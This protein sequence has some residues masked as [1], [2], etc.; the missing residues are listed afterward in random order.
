MFRHILSTFS[1]SLY[2]VPVVISS[3]LWNIPRFLELETCYVNT[4][5]AIQ[6]SV[7]PTAL[8][9]STSYTRNRISK[10]ETNNI[11]IP[12]LRDYILLSNFLVMTL[13]PFL[14]LSVFNY[15]LFKTIRRSGEVNQKTTARQRRDQKIAAILILLVAVFG[16][17]NF[18]RII[19]NVYEVKFL[20][21]Y[22]LWFLWHELSSTNSNSGTMYYESTISPSGESCLLQCVL[23][24]EVNA[25][26]S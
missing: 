9:L 17:C 5:L 2:I 11:I 8:R 4:T 25:Q 6:P 23:C 7:C 26:L 10:I 19:T 12:H 22:T 16:I 13:L 3:L 1:S 20:F 14:L 24:S 15:L 18:V 21:L